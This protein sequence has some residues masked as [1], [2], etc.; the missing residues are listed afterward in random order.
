MTVVVLVG[1]S[2][3]AVA[4]PRHP[5]EEYRCISLR[6]TGVSGITQVYSVEAC[7]V[8]RGGVVR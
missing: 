5:H 3:V 1:R 7:I 8:R 4:M 6:T 2:W